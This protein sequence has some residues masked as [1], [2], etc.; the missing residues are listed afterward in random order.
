MQVEHILDH[1]YLGSSVAE[2]DKHLR[3]YFIQNAAYKNLITN[4]ADIIAGD[5]G[6][7]KSAIFKY[8]DSEYTSIEIPR[9]GLVFMPG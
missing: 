2:F 3:K 6:T 7:G 5:K 9:C 8:L 4:R 1:L